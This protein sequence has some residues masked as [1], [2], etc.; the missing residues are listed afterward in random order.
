LSRYQELRQ[1]L[2]E[3]IASEKYAV[4][5]RFPTEHELCARFGVSRHTVREALRTLEEQGLLARQAGSGTTVLART[6]PKLYTQT[7]DSLAGLSDYAAETRFDR[8][9]DGFVVARAALAETLDCAPGERWLRLAGARLAEDGTPTCWTEIFVADRYAAVRD[10]GAED[11][12][13]LYDRIQKQF[14]LDIAQ[15]EQRI[16]AVAM[17]GEMARILGVEH[18]SPALMTRRRYFADGESAPFEISLSFHP[19]ARY[20]YTQLLRRDQGPRRP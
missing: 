20:A 17:P 11:S 12:A 5:D 3:E 10:A 14:G 1:I 6:A 16:S 15:V 4:G 9:H 8:R 18:G 19:G 13:P 2:T 7:L